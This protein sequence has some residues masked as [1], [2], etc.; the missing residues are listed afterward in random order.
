MY[1]KIYCNILWLFVHLFVQVII[2][3]SE[4]AI[5]MTENEDTIIITSFPLLLAGPN[6]IYN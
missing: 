4:Y 1:P 6:A 3:R 5:S 2:G